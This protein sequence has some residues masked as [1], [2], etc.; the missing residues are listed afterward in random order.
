MPAAEA[1]T[2]VWPASGSTA[3]TLCTL[4][5]MPRDRDIRG[6]FST[7]DPAIETGRRRRFER[8]HISDLEEVVTL[9]GN[10]C[11]ICTAP[12][13]ST[14]SFHIDHNH[15]AG[16]IRGLLCFS[17][18]SAVGM[19]RDRPELLRAAAKYIDRGGVPDIGKTKVGQF[20]F[21]PDERGNL[22]PYRR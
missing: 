1:K 20:V 22:Q 16:P 17:C 2:V 5:E 9:Q 19:M 3:R 6:C 18:N 14:R 21:R 12:F 4:P 8:P 11:A 15:S 10:A 13:K 7:R